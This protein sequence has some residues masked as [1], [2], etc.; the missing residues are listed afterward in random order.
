MYGSV[1]DLHL[2]ASMTKFSTI[3]MDPPWRYSNASTRGAASDH[4][5]TMTL[6][7][8]ES[9]PIPKLAA[10][11]CH[12]HLWTT[13]AFLFDAAKIMERWGFEYKG[14]FLWVKSQMGMGN[15][16]RVSHEFLL[17]GVKGGMVFEDHGLKSWVE[18]PR[19]KKHSSKPEEIRQL[20]ELASPGPRI[21]L[22][23]RKL[24]SGWTV[25]GNE[26]TYDLP[27]SSLPIRHRTRPRA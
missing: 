18:L 24:I 14:I 12:L 5:P 25:W 17:L 23:G 6:K 19:S 21:E 2:L 9:L 10:D 8:I 16:W 27:D 22:F 13:N 15:Y 3:Y 1:K 26:I 11:K 7:E 20:V 4:Y